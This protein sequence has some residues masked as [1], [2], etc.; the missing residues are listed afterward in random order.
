MPT[1]HSLDELIARKAVDFADQLRKTSGILEK[2][3]EIRIEAER[4]LAFIEREAGVK[5]EGRHEFTVGYGISR[6]DR[7]LNKQASLTEIRM[8]RIGQQTVGKRSAGL[9]MKSWKC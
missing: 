9:P 6:I 1:S 7:D 2:E 8:T 3:E 5:I 4:Q